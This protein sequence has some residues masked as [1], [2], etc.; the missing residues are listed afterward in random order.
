MRIASD[1]PDPLFQLESVWIGR[2][3]VDPEARRYAV[4]ECGLAR[5]GQGAAPT[6]RNLESRGGGGAG[7]PAH[8][9]LVFPS[10]RICPRGEFYWY[11]LIGCRVESESGQWVGTVREIWETGAHDVLLVEDE[12]GCSSTRADRRTADDRDR[13]RCQADRGRRSAGASRALLRT[14]RGRAGAEGGGGDV[15]DRRA[16]DLSGTVSALSRDRLRRRR[17][18]AGCRRRRDPRSSR[19]GPG[20]T[21]L[22]RRRPL[23]WWTGHD[24]D[25]RAHGAGDREPGWTQ[26]A[27]SGGTCRV[28]LAP[29]QPALSGARLAELVAGPPLLLVCGRYEGI[30]QRILELAVD[31]EISI[32]DY[33]LSG[34]E[35]PAMVLIEGLVRL[36]PGVLG[37]PSSIETESFGGGDFLEGPQYTRP[38]IYRGLAV[39]EVLRSGNHAAIEAMA[40]RA[41][42]CQ[43]ARTST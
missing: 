41:R 12:G 3:P 30:D 26:G 7:G 35:L 28:P 24:H 43:D 18:P 1:S 15:A 13:Y 2:G 22:G 21:S 29:G 11:E 9:G 36:L 16:D 14:R 17:P 23:R 31:E 20:S 25:A 42:P 19:L 5:A 32:G 34:G 8:H 37:N 27:R 39:P 4:L 10:C 33:V 6:G 38:P 40:A